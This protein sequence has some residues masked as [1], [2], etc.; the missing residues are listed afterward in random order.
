VDRV[1]L[2]SLFLFF[3][4]AL[5]FLVPVSPDQSYSTVKS[6]SMNNVTEVKIV[7][8]G[9]DLFEEHEYKIRGQYEYG[10]IHR[11]SLEEGVDSKIRVASDGW[12]L[13]VLIS[14][15]SH[16][17]THID[18]EDSGRNLHDELGLK[19]V[20][21]RVKLPAFYYYRHIPYLKKECI[22]SSGEML[23]DKVLV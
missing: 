9:Q 7:F 2:C 5:F 4:L 18:F 23:L 17:A 6:F 8:E 10:G 13:F 15:C 12:P 22:F 20:N 14:A 1:E 11:P 3:L 21:G 19:K 16:E